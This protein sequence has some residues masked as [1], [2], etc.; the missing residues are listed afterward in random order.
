MELNFLDDLVENFIRS[1]LLEEHPRLERFKAVVSCLQRHQQRQFLFAT[2]SL[3][4]RKGL[5][6][7]TTLDRRAMQNSTLS[8]NVCGC[9]F[10]LRE[11]ISSEVSSLASVLT[12]WLLRINAISTELTRAI[13]CALPQDQRE[14]LLEESWKRFGDK[15]CVQHN[16]IIQQD[17]KL[18]AI[19]SLIYA[20]ILK[21][22]STCSDAAHHSWICSPK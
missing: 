2:M 21:R 6:M 3:M 4:T 19:N 8:R 9:A 7:Q 1:T 14:T 10:F 20:Q 5:P 11:I 16:S 17:S 15:L 12:S 22:Y 13:I 18:E